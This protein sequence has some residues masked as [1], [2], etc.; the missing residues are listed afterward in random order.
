SCPCSG[1][2]QRSW[3][4]RSSWRPSSPAA[5]RSGSTGWPTGCSGRWP[6]WWAA[7]SSAQRSASSVPSG[8][9]GRSSSISSGVPCPAP[10]LADPP[11]DRPVPV[12]P[13]HLPRDPVTATHR[14]QVQHA[15]V[16]PLLGPGHPC[17]LRSRPV[18]HHRDPSD[19]RGVLAVLGGAPVGGGLPRAVHH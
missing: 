15:L 3:P 7:C 19:R 2:P 6:W 11:G 9:A 12:V 8:P 4:P 13:D 17:L 16:V 14:I 10:V 18:L 5:S 1:R